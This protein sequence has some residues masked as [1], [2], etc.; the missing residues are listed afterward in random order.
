[1]LETLPTACPTARCLSADLA[2]GLITSREVVQGC[3]D[4]IAARDPNLGAFVVVGVEQAIEAAEAWDKARKLGD[5]VP[6]LAGVPLAV[7]DNIDTVDLP[8]GYGSEIYD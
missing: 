2:A 7:K 6:T 4:R 3:L 5:K 1:M 8:T